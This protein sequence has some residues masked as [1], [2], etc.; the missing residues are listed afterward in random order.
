MK[1]PVS[2]LKDHL[3]THADLAT[4]TRTLTALGLEVDAVEDRGQALAAFTVGHVVS[5]EKHPNADKLQVCVVDTGRGT[6]QVVCGAPNARAGMKGVFAPAGTHIPGTGV[7]LKKGVIRG[8]ESHGMLCSEREM[9]LSDEH[10]GIIELPEDAPVGTSFAALMG[11]DDPLIVIGLTPDRADCAA[12]RGIARDLAAAGLG[13]L[14]AP[15]QAVEPVAGQFASPITVQ[16]KLPEAAANACPLF[17]GRAFRGL[18][19]GPSPRWLQDKLVAI[20][21][22]PISTLVD[23]TNY[24]THDIARPLHVFDTAKLSGNIH[25]RLARSGETLAALN[26]KSYSLDETMTVIADDAQALALGGI[27][28]GEGSGCSESTT[29]MFL[30]CALFDAVRTGATGR[31]L[32]V[33]S[34]ARYRF[35]RGVDPD[36]VFSGI[37][38]ATRLIL[39][40]CGGEASDLVVAGAVPEWRRSLTLR[41][42]RVRDL[43]GTEVPLAEQGRILNALG[44]ETTEEADGSLRV[45]IPSWRADMH[46][47]ADLVE[48]VLRV[49]GYDQIPVTSLRKT[50]ALTRPALS[51]QQRRTAAVRRVLATRGLCEAVTWSFLSSATADHFGGVTEALRL[52]NPISS[53]LDVMRPSLLPNLIQAAGRNANRG[54]A[55]AGLFEIGPAFRNAE[56]NGQERIAAGVRSGSWAPRHWSALEKEKARPV[57]VYDAKADALAVLESAGA[58]VA[59]LQITTDAPGWYHPGRSGTLRLG[60]TVLAGFGEMHP[61]TLAALDVKG[62]LVGFEVFL[63]AIA[64]PK[65][66][67][68]TARPL[69]KLSPFQPLNRDFAFVVDDA[70]EAE[71]LLRAIRSA[72]KALI[73]DVGV[74]DVYRGPGVAAGQKS[75]AVSVSVQPADKPLTEADLEALAGRIVAAVTKATGGVLRG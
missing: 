24:L 5:A 36:T 47:E 38:R 74:F 9:G 29:T 30:E 32:G 46:G 56:P 43:G 1:L 62:P 20:G 51:P 15:P 11:L 48:E 54:Y 13:T 34:D 64:Q 17:V 40:L 23:I 45:A 66:K 2:W 63:D 7:D 19:N 60:G 61:E 44:C 14:K 72:D 22:R 6:I 65:R 41:P 58:P 67:A 33:E 3:E 70:V 42:T 68:G 71:R 73:R 69:L 53:D 18:R 16:L 55:D 12:V 26:G 8:V 59:N 52:L 35:E 39:E 75:L 31:R 37:E 57:D 50:T 49:V 10:K 27:I 25:V 28:G 4:L 21:L